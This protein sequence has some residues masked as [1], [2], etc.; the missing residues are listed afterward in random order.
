MGLGGA[1]CDAGRNPLT[2]S[3][4]DYGCIREADYRRMQADVLVDPLR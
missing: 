2:P 1:V 3:N 4:G